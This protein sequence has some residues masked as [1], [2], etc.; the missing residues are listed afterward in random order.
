MCCC[1]KEC[2]CGKTCNAFCWFVSCVGSYYT[3][4][5]SLFG[6]QLCKEAYEERQKRRQELKEEYT[7]L[8]RAESPNLQMINESEFI[9]HTIEI[10][11][12]KSEPYI[13]QN[14]ITNKKIY[15][16]RLKTIQEY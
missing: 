3:I 15:V 5:C 2:C 11:P 14:S 10:G 4:C 16:P 9:Q 6:F 1:L 8:N 12:P 13:Q 7:H